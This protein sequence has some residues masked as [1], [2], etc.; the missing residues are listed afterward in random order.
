MTMTKMSADELLSML[1]G[2]CTEQGLRLDETS[3]GYEVCQS[4]VHRN[5][6]FLPHVVDAHG[7]DFANMDESGEHAVRV[8][9]TDHIWGTPYT[10]ILKKNL[11]RAIRLLTSDGPLYTVCKGCENCDW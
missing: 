2:L 10:N 3:D 5:R 11:R 1:R 7:L 8:I 4:D 9:A 6:K